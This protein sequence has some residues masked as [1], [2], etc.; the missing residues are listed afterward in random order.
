[1]SGDSLH[2]NRKGAIKLAELMAEAID[3]EGIELAEGAVMN[4]NT[5]YMFKNVNSGLYL[6]VANGSAAAGT[7]VQQGDSSNPEAKNTWQL[8]AASDGY[9]YMYSMLGDGKTYLLDL[10]YGKKDNGTNIGIYTDTNNDAQLFKFSKNS[11]GSYLI[12]T[13]NSKDRSCVEVVSA[14]TESGAN[15]QQWERNGHACQSWVAE[16]VNSSI[17]QPTTEEIGKLVYG[18]VNCNGT[19]DIADAVITKLYIINP[20]KYSL[21]KQGLKNADVH[22]VGNGIN[23]QDALAI[24]SYVISRIETLPV[25][26]KTYQTMYPAKDATISGGI[27]ENVNSGYTEDCYVNLNNEVGSN[28]TFNVEVGQTGNYYVAIRNA[29]ASA[30]DRKMKIEVN[31]AGEYWVQSFLSTGDW[32]KWVETG[33]VLPLFAGMNTIKMTSLMSEGA[34]NLDY[35][36]IELTDEPIAETYDPNSG[37]INIGGNSTIYIAGDSTVQSYRESYKPQ[38]GWGYYLQNYLNDVTVS[39]QSIAGRSSKSFYDNG[40][41]DTI[42]G[43]IKEGDYLMVQFAINDADYT[44]TERY[45]PVCGKVQN[46]D[47]GSFEYYIAKYIE[48]AKSKGATPILVTTVIGLKAYSNGK[49]VNS[50]TNYC[51][52]MK[53]MASYYKIPCIDL[54]TLMVNHYNSIGYDAAYKYHL[55]GAVDGST[56]M[57]HFTETGANA[58]AGLV[59]NALKGLNLPVSKN[60]K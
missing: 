1:M 45:A 26:E 43:T 2:P 29:N 41:L 25:G 23:A 3:F 18:D 14:K 4:E 32:T 21:S 58:V 46:P 8:K 48:G 6:E 42:L 51:Q 33:I 19:V 47:T 17:S 28:I 22:N 11:D 56:D 49:F 54:N 12:L 57:T 15:V 27:T 60:V 30:N 35:I 37:D 10:D 34:P 52:A 24:Q 5:K 50:Y 53:D 40:R 16:E 38:Q 31:G 44:K 39:N 9:Y 7:N 13:K 59:A 20:S 55:C 36:R